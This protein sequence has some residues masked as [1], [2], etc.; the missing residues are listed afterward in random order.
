MSIES[1]SAPG[2]LATL[3]PHRLAERF[4]RTRRQSTS[5]AEPLSAEDCSAQSMDDASPTKWHLAHTTW[6]FD[7]FVLGELGTAVG[8]AH[9]EYR[10]LFNSYYESVGA[11]HPRPRRGMLTRPS[12]DEVQD[13]RARVDDALATLLEADQL[14]SEM[15]ARVEL[16]LHHEMQHQELLLTD[17]HHLLAQNPLFP[18]YRSDLG[19]PRDGAPPTLSFVHVP[20]GIRSIGHDESSFAF[21][22]EGPRHDVLVPAF[23]IASRPVT[24]GEYLAFIEDGGYRDHRHWLSEGFE[25][26]RREGWWAPEY[27]TEISG[28]TR[29]V[30]HFSLAGLGSLALDAPVC[31]L[32]YFEADAY[33]RWAGARLP[34]EFE[35]EVAAGGVSVAGN[36]ADG[37]V[38]QPVVGAATRG[39]RLHKIYGDCW[40]WTQSSYAAYPGYRSSEG[41]LGEYNGKFMCNQYVL[42]GGSCATPTDHIRRSYRNFFPAGARWQKSGLR[43]ARDPE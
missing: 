24:N 28:K 17:I 25:T 9:P 27:W 42:R 13:Y 5:L 1:V 33:A 32:S 22:N 30:N 14:S 2:N 21:D 12:L 8:G 36:F 16:G 37:D 38:L 20:N 19:D 26:L 10:I 34:T 4:L 29:E 41:A 18:A 43:L 3:P 31:H 23:E 39:A 7:T 35:W 6:F 40:E 15:C 11:Q